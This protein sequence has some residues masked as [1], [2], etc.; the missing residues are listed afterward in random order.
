MASTTSTPTQT[1]TGSCHC[2][3]ITYKV[4]LPS[5]HPKVASRCNCT[6]C[7]KPN[8]TSLSVAA[9]AFN[10]LT[11]SSKAEL[12][13][14]QPGSKDRHRYF[15]RNCGV[16]VFSEGSYVFGDKTYDFFTVS[17]TTLDQPQEGLELNE[18]KYEYYDGRADNWM[19]GKNVAPW[20]SGAL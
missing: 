2:N 7:Q 18:W 8:Y 5:D 11:P 15:C 10:L 1:F 17:F 3:A 16:H 14:Y 6:I 12:A 13:D 19:A 4:T 20:K 9:S